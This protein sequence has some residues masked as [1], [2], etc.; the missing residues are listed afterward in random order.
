MQ[1]IPQCPMKLL[2]KSPTQKLP[3]NQVPQDLGEWVEDEDGNFV[4]RG[5]D[6]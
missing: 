5:E 3:Q 2:L 6:D 4:K 1:K